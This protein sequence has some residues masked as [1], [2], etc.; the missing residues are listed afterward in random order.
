[1]KN[2]TT[3]PL[4]L[5]HLMKTQLVEAFVL[6]RRIQPISVAGTETS[7]LGLQ[8][9]CPRMCSQAKRNAAGSVL[10]IVWHTDANSQQLIKRERERESRKICKGDKSLC[11]IAKN[12][13]HSNSEWAI[14]HDATQCFG[15]AFKISPPNLLKLSQLKSKW[16]MPLRSEC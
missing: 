14:S 13:R 16:E 7:Q 11:R 1:M 6:S 4:N 9:W 8:L 10:N 5:R 15:H 3:F 12:R 2:F